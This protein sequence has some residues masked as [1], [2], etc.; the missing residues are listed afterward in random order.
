MQLF[1]KDCL[2]VVVTFPLRVFLGCVLKMYVS[3]PN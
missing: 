2:L 1:P 3:Q